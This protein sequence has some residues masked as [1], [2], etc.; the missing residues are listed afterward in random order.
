M[1]RKRNVR[2]AL[3]PCSACRSA[4]PSVLAHTIADRRDRGGDGHR[5]VVAVGHVDVGRGQVAA[6][7]DVLRQARQA[8]DPST[9]P[10]APGGLEV[11][12]RAD[13]RVEE[14][15]RVAVVDDLVVVGDD[16]E[17]LAGVLAHVGLESCGR[18]QLG[19]VLHPE[20]VDPFRAI[21]DEHVAVCDLPAE[22]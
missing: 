11:K 21:D 20:V 13:Q 14:S 9:A 15:E 5:P 19:R 18:D 12:L 1:W 10:Q 16:P 7:L 22:A 6:E 8:P 3:A 2:W 17:H 4:A